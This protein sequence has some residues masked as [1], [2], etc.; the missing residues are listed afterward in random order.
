MGCFPTKEDAAKAVGRFRAADVNGPPRAPWDSLQNYYNGPEDQIAKIFHTH[1]R[2]KKRQNLPHDQIFPHINPEEPKLPKIRPWLPMMLAMAEHEGNWLFGAELQMKLLL[3]WNRVTNFRRYR[4]SRSWAK[5]E[6]VKLHNMERIMDRFAA[7]PIWWK[8]LVLD[9]TRYPRPHN[10][11]AY[12]EAMGGV[13][14]EVADVEEAAAVA[15]AGND[16]SSSTLPQFH[17]C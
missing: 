16:A 8:A 15:N 7:C 1:L 3:S 14:M 12:A 13:D 4:G 11:R 2:W 17:R 5:A 10:R 6:V 9:E